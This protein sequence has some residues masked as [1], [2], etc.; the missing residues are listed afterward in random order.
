MRR[1]TLLVTVLAILAGAIT[2][3]AV[4]PASPASVPGTAPPPTT[5]PPAVAET[6][7]LDNPTGLNTRY[8]DYFANPTFGDW[9]TIVATSP[10]SPHPQCFMAAKWGNINYTGWTEAMAQLKWLRGSACL[11]GGGHV[12]WYDTRYKTIVTSPV[13]WCVGSS[14]QPKNYA[15]CRQLADGSILMSAGLPTSAKRDTPI[16]SAEFI[17]CAG[18]SLFPWVIRYANCDHHWWRVQF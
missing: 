12:T 13:N 4:T 3:V 9:H 2:A 7:I 17:V 6:E 14:T 1:V 5:A 18:S 10:D 16:L 8:Y 15:T 11:W